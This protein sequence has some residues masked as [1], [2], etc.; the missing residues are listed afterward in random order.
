MCH[1]FV[2]IVLSL[3]FAI[4]Y[5]DVKY[6][7]YDKTVRGLTSEYFKILLVICDTFKDMFIIYSILQFLLYEI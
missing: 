4:I 7:L 5:M 6:W 3:M 1:S 2:I